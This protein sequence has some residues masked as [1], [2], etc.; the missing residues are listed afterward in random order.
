MDLMTTKE[1]STRWKW[2]GAAGKGSCFLSW[3]FL[4]STEPENSVAIYQMCQNDKTNLELILMKRYVVKLIQPHLK[5]TLIVLTC[6]GLPELFCGGE[7]DGHIL[8]RRDHHLAEARASWQLARLAR[9]SHVIVV[10][11]TGLQLYRH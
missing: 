5:L 3:I 11:Y 4:A 8:G 6:S 9:S 7:H 2:T 1:S 10:P